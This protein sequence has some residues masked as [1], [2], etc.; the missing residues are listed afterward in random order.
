MQVLGEEK[1]S[2]PYRLFVLYSQLIG[3]TTLSNM[4]KIHFVPV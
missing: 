2:G 3:N 1:I 4:T